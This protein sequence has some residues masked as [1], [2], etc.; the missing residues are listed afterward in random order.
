MTL[1]GSGGTYK[2]NTQTFG[3]E[4]KPSPDAYG[5]KINGSNNTSFGVKQNDGS[6]QKET[7]PEVKEYPFRENIERG[8]TVETMKKFGVRAGLSTK[9]GK[10]VEAWYF[11]SYNQD[12][13]ITGYTKQDL[14]K[15][16]T[17]KFHWTT[18]GT[19]KKENKLF[20]QDTMEKQ[21][22]RH[23][24]LIITEGQWDCLSVW[25][26]RKYV[27]SKNEKYAELN[28]Y[29]V[30]IPNGTKSAKET[31]VINSKFIKT[32]SE[33]I[34]HFDNDERTEAD[35]KDVKRGKEA[36]EDVVGLFGSEDIRVKKFPHDERFKDASDF[37]QAGVK[38][39]KLNESMTY[40]DS[41]YWKVKDADAEK[42][43]RASDFDLDELLKPLEHGIVINDF[44][45]LDE[46]LAG[47]RSRECT[48]LT[49]MSGFGKTTWAD[50]VANRAL[51]QGKKV[52]S[53]Y[54]EE[55]NNKTMQRKIASELGVGFKEFRKNP[56]GQGFTREQ[57]AEVFK[58]IVEKD[59]VV[60]LD[61]FG[62]MPITELMSKIKYMH[63]VEGCDLIVLDHLSMVISGSDIKDER[64]ELDMVMTQIA[65]FCESHDVHII[66]IVHVNREV[67]KGQQAPKD[68]EG[69]ER[70]YWLKINLQGLRGSA[71]I[72]QM[73][74]NVIALEGEILPNRQRGRV[75]LVVLK[76]RE[77][78]ELGEADYF[79]LDVVTW[80]VML[81]DPEDEMNNTNVVVPPP[82]ERPKAIDRQ[83]LAEQGLDENGEVILPF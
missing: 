20:G 29:V 16:K 76:N 17:E 79:K 68:K 7:V 78:G 40:L 22:G 26:S 43:V 5:N 64:K 18:V 3:G 72:E 80:Q 42:I 15:D 59:N 61:H 41:L 74:N 44:P 13:H 62:S 83:A 66:L 11:P 45:K 25:Q 53:I 56:L 34:I 35:K 54:L 37:L 60:M 38:S 30:S 57:I 81:C 31:C 48:V 50:I 21:S 82:Q 32:F 28:P 46:M 39:G 55:P 65:S 14:T 63:V 69:N 23:N 33:M 1:L 52:G 70:P 19:V 9:D 75:R 8:I 47:L 67:A 49:S 6:Y 73:A 12:G 71:G 10:T 77:G 51:E 2:A 27:L 36:T 24:T 58:R 4:N